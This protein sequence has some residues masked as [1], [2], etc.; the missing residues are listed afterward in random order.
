[1]N[2]GLLA[3]FSYTSAFY[4][5][6]DR[7]HPR[8]PAFPRQ[9]TLE[10]IFFLPF[11]DN[12]FLSF[13]KTFLGWNVFVAL[14][15]GFRVRRRLCPFILSVA[16]IGLSRHL[17]NLMRINNLIT[18]VQNIFLSLADF[19]HCYFIKA[20]DHSFYGFTGAINHLGCWENSWKACKNGSWFTS[21]SRVLPT[22]HVVYYAGKPIGKVIYCLIS[23][24]WLELV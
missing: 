14:L 20:I 12:L 3:N 5:S 9:N 23:V 22:S 1:M 18:K 7:F 19:F 2:F 4:F 6:D 10:S 15:C 16:V 21:F 13:L 8:I 17:M 24:Q 11:T